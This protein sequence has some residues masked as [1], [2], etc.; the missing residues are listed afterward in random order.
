M[1][2]ILVLV[3]FG[4]CLIGFSY[5][6]EAIEVDQHFYDCVKEQRTTIGEILEENGRPDN[7]LTSG[8][9]QPTTGYQILEYRGWRTITHF[10]ILNGEVWKKERRYK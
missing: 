2:K 8:C 1:R 4:F 5:Q 6:A 9:A 7:W 10:H 3:I